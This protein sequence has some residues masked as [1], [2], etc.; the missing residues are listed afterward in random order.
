M[1]F[2]DATLVAAAEVLG[3]KRILTIDKHFF[4]YRI[5]N[6]THFELLP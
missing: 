2:A 4:I 5:N 1:D 6:Q 3:V